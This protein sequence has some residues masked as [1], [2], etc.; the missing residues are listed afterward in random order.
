MS[1]QMHCGRILTEDEV[2]AMVA[3]IKA[4]KPCEYADIVDAI[5]TG[6]LDEAQ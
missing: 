3:L 4:K 2:D 1:A 5:A 6:I